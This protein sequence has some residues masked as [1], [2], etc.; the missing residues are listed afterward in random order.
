MHNPVKPAAF[1]VPDTAEFHYFT[2]F[3]AHFRLV[4]VDFTVFALGLR[5]KG[6]FF[7][8][9]HCISKQFST[10]GAKLICASV[11]FTA[12]NPYETP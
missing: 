7:I 2:Y 10:C 6:A 4:A 5:V 3:L 12:E 9:S 1:D 8:A 11:V